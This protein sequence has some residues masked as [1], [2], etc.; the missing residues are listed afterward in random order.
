M[1]YDNEIE[2]NIERMPA[3]IEVK[4]EDGEEEIRVGGEPLKI[5][6][7]TYA[8][9]PDKPAI[10]D[11]TLEGNKSFEELGHYALTNIEIENILKN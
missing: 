4:S 6:A 10:N 5:G 8:G 7:S 11:V 3:E 9:L 2:L 1:P